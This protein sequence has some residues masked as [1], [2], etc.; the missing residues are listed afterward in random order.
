[1]AIASRLGPPILRAEKTR[2]DSE[3]VRMDWQEW[4]TGRASGTFP[5]RMLFSNEWK[6]HAIPT[7]IVPQISNDMKILERNDIR[8]MRIHGP[9]FPR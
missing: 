1:M 6:G 5:R 8:I 3:S 7:L 2:G 9:T 4:F